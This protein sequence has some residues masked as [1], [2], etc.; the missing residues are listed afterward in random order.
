MESP[1]ETLENQIYDLIS[2]FMKNEQNCYIGE[3]NEVRFAI[4]QLID[5]TYGGDTV[6]RCVDCKVDIG[7]SNP[8]QYCA[9]THCENA[10]LDDY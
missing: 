1:R 7:Q 3:E 6:N 8:R 2:T 9:K 5:T 4:T 10:P